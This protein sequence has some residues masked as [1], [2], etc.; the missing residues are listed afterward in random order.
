MKSGAVSIHTRAAQ[1]SLDQHSGA[2]S[3][4]V[5]LQDE[6]G[7]PLPGFSLDDCEELFDD[8]LDRR[9]HWKPK[10][11]LSPLIGQ[12]VQVRFV[13]RDADLYSFQFRD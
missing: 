2:G 8:T 1:K 13:L 4:R 6:Q 10:T 7:K 5:E 3:L 9:V 12:S 11:D